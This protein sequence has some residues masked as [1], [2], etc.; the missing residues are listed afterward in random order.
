[1]ARASS[2]RLS[3]SAMRPDVWFTYHLYHK[4]PDWLGP[5]VSRALDIPYVVAEA[6]VAP[7]AARR[8]VGGRLR[9]HR[10]PPIEA[11]AATI[12]LNPVDVA[13]VRKR[14]R[15]GARRMSACRRSSTSRPSRA[16]SR[17]SRRGRAR[18]RPARCG[19]ITVAMMRP[20]AKLASYRVL[21]DALARVALPRIGSWSIV[22]DGPARTEVEAAFARFD[23][24]AD[25]LRRFPGRADAWPRGCASSDLFVWPAIDEAFGMAL[26]E[27]QACGLPVSPAT[28]AA[29][30]AWWRRVARACWSRWATPARLPLAIERLHRP[31][32]RCGGGWRAKPSPTRTREH[33]L[34]A[35]AVAPR[36]GAAP[37]HAEHGAV[38][39]RADGRGAR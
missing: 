8:P 13:G 37:G 30:R 36:R 20:G 7:K 22:G 18:S 38:A 34:P 24:I 11:A 26:I 29:W 19:S 9:R 23:P 4:A 5:A 15:P 33:D 17:A 16:R 31:R 6:S 27:A 10:W 25:S 21:A 32:P 3:A 1:M 39:D 35:A 2:A 28:A 12:F 14:A